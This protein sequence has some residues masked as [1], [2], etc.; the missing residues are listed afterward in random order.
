MAPIHS[1]IG[2]TEPIEDLAPLGHRAPA[3]LVAK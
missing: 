1:R 3:P 2:A